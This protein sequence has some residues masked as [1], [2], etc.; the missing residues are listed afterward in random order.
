M[1]VLLGNGNG[2]F[3]GQVYTID[4]TDPFVVSINRTTPPI[5]DHKRHGRRLHRH[6]QRSRHRRRPRRFRAGHHRHGRGPRS[7]QVTPVSTSVYTVAVSGITGNGTLGLNLVDNGTIH[8]LAG[9]PLGP[10]DGRCFVRDPGHLRHGRGPDRGRGRGPQRRRQARPRHRQLRQQHRERA[11][12][13]RQRHL[14]GPADHL[15]H[16]CA[17]RSRWRSRT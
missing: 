10:P 15:R 3:T 4:Q 6:L 7:T 8:D 16:G 11:A 13:Q 5:G 14:P 2:N 1:S 17:T 12:G 9:N